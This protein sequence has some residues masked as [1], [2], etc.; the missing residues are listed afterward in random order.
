[1]PK[2]IRLYET[3]GSEKLKWEEGPVGDRGPARC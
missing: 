3:G 2:A 1:M